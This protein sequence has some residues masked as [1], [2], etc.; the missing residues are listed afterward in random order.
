MEL[1]VRCLFYHYQR[2]FSEGIFRSKIFPSHISAICNRVTERGELLTWRCDC[3]WKVDPVFIPFPSL[4]GRV[5][6]T[7]QQNLSPY[8]CLKASF[9]RIILTILFR[10]CREQTCSPCCK[11]FPMSGKHDCASESE[12]SPCMLTCP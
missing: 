6:S 2:A 8:Q 10:F 9:R 12:S 5:K 1:Q 11:Q 3:A 4:K 7:R